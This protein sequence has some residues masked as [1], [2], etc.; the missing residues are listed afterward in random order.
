MSAATIFALASGSG[1]AA[2]AIVR[3]SGPSAGAALV[4]LTR[5]P[6][7]APRHARLAPL[8]DPDTGETL[9][10]ALTLWFPGPRSQTGEDVAE[11]HLHGGR[12]VIEGVAAA[13]MRLPGLRPAEPGEFTRRAFEQGKLDLTEAEAIADLVDADTAAQRRQALRQQGGE[14]ARLYDAWRDRLV[15][16]L[17]HVEAGI[18]FPDEDLPASLDANAERA[19]AALI[20]DLA[21]HLDDGGRGERLRDGLSVAIIGPPN[22]GKSSLLNALARRDAAIVSA[23]SGTTRDVIE[24]HLD[25]GGYPV[26]LADTAGLRDSADE[27]EQEGI[28][29]ARRRA[30]DADIKIAVFDGDLWPHIDPPTRALIDEAT[31]PVVSKLDRHGV[32][33]PLIGDRPALA[34]SVRTGMGLPALIARLTAFA[35]AHLDTAGRPTLTRQRHRLALQDCLTALRRARTAPLPELVA[36]DIR[37]ATRALGRITGRVAVEEVLEVIFRDF[38]IGK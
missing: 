36:E 15:S 16:L 5:R 20:T 10:R 25:L 26:V 27:V 6:L 2:V 18:D 7:P 34:L 32:A 38:C 12:A 37:L 13:L 30:A 23:Q 17:G 19:L 35:A 8:I 24:V 14:L 29:R 28:R 3:L 4:A 31:L 1:R 11:L 9:D 33:A 22:A 21:A